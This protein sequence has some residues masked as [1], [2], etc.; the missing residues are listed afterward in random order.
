MQ[1][2]DLDDYTEI[3][4]GGKGTR[5]RALAVSEPLAC[6]YNSVEGTIPISTSMQ[7]RKRCPTQVGRRVPTAS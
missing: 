3:T 2:V 5:A 7:Q 1:A 6:D 4:T